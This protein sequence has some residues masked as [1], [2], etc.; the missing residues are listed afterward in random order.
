[1]DLLQDVNR[2]TYQHWNHP[3]TYATKENIILGHTQKE[4]KTK[5]IDSFNHKQ[6]VPTEHHSRI[7]G[8]ASLHVPMIRTTF[9]N[10]FHKHFRKITVVANNKILARSTKH[11]HLANADMIESKQTTM[12]TPIRKHNW[13]EA[14]IPE[15]QWSCKRSPETRD[16]YQ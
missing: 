16:I 14:K 1:M 10:A 13:E 11:K 5:E 3:C 9:W 6:E 12:D 2:I 15:D 8:C 4:H 7:L